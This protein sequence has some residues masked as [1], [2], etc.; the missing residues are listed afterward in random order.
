MDS[1]IQFLREMPP[2]TRHEQTKWIN[3]NMFCRSNF[4]VV[5]VVVRP[6]IPTVVILIAVAWRES[7]SLSPRTSS[8][9]PCSVQCTLALA[10]SPYV[11][12]QRDNSLANRQFMNSFSLM[13]WLTAIWTGETLNYKMF[14]KLDFTYQ[15][16]STLNII[17]DFKPFVFFNGKNNN[18]DLCGFTVSL[19]FAGKHQGLGW[20]FVAIFF[21][22]FFFSF[23]KWF[24]GCKKIEFFK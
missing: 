6:S 19:G 20:G 21:A 3:E 15:Q 16:F 2:L 4:Y 5:F 7:F 17:W 14:S 11:R 23:Q 9:S 12:W 13:W 1:V 10:G 18:K 22:H 8:I 24:F